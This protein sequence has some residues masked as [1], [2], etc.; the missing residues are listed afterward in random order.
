MA[1]PREI[2]C[3]AQPSDEVAGLSIKRSMLIVQTKTGV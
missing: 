3:H 2:F 1:L